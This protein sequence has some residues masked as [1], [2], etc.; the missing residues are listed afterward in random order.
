MAFHSVPT[1]KYPCGSD[2]RS[3]YCSRADTCHGAARRTLPNG[4]STKKAHRAIAQSGREHVSSTLDRV[5]QMR[6]R[7]V[8]GQLLRVAITTIFAKIFV[9]MC[10]IASRTVDPTATGNAFGHLSLL[11]I[12]MTTPSDL[13]FKLNF[14]NQL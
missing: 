5:P 4:D 7:G 14:Y 1:E 11:G 8:F 2:P 9:G 6:R 13:T 10:G 12:S 3:R